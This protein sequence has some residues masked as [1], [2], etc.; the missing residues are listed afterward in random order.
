MYQSLIYVSQSLIDPPDR[1]REIDQ[2]VAISQDRNAQLAVRGALIF[3]E[4]HF[5]QILEGPEKAV[6]DLMVSINRDR[7]HQKVMVIERKPIDAYRF[8]DWS[9]AYWGAATYMDQ[10][11]A[12][13]VEKHDALEA[14][15]QAA[16]LYSL[17]H[18]LA[19]ESQKLRGPI[20]SPSPN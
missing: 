6:D 15:G 14:M 19:R 4:R 8:S 7:R 2:I 10:Q 12:R 18:L 16:D 11:V 20:G 13:I 5:A 1:A 17:I 3:T 9:L